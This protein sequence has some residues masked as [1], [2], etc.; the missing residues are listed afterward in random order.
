MIEIFSTL[1]ARLIFLV[2]FAVIPA[3]VLIVYTNFEQRQQRVFELQQNATQVA[4][5]ISQNQNRLFSGAQQ[6]LIALAQLP[7]IRQHDAVACNKLLAAIL[8]QFSDTY[9]QFA[10]FM[11][12]GDLFCS[13]PANNTV[14]NIA[15]RHH[16]K[17]VIATRKVA[18]S[19]YVIS[20]LLGKPS[21]FLSQPALNNDGEVEALINVGMDLGWIA[22]LI[23]DAQLPQ[24]TVLTVFDAN[25]IT[26]ARYP[27]PEKW[28]GK[29]VPEQAIIARLK[30][31]DNEG[32]AT[33]DGPDGISRLYGFVPL[34]TQKTDA[35]VAVGVP[36]SLALASAND[37]LF[38][39][40]LLLG[41]VTFFA[42]IA[43]WLGS[44]YF[45]VRP[46]DALVNTAGRLSNGDLSA[47]VA[48]TEG[49][50]E[51]KKLG[52]A[53]DT[54]AASL[55]HKETERVC[56]GKVLEEKEQY[57]RMF[58]QSTSDCIWNWDMATNTV[59]RSIGF[60]RLFGYDE[61][62]IDPS[63]K[64]WADRLHP[65][66]K[67][68]VLQK[69]EAAIAGGRLTY[70]YEYRFQ[71]KD[72]S[73]AIIDDH[74]CF[75]R[76]DKGKAIRS[77][78]AMR[79]ITEQKQADE[80]MRMAASIYQS[81]TAAIMVTDK[82]NR[83][84]DVNPAF[85]HITGYEFD[86]VVG[87]NPNILQSGKHDESFY[88]E[89]WHEILNE[90]QWQ[91]E[92]WDRRKNGEIYAKWTNISV[93]R[94]PDG[95]VHRHLA[96]FSDITEKKHKD[97]LIWTQA[98]YDI[99]TNLPNRRLLHD[100]LEQE[101]KKA[102]RNKLPLAVLFIDLDR[103][104][105]INDTLGHAKGDLLLIEAAHRISGCVRETDTIGR[106]GGDE[107]TVILPEFG[108]RRHIERIAQDVIDALSKPFYFEND[109]NG[110][111]ISA[112]IGITLYPEDA[113]NI[114]E[115]LKHADQAMYQAK[116]EGRHRFSY[117]IGSM[118]QEAQEKLE[119]TNDL[120]HALERREL[121]VYYQPIID[122]TNGHIV[123]SEALLRWIHPDRGMVSPVIFIPLA[124][125]SGLIHEIGNWVFH[126]A[127][128][129][130]EKWRKETGSVFPVSVNKSPVQ[131]EHT[132][133]E[134]TWSDQL[135]NLDLPGN[136]INVEITEGLLLKES[137][138]IKQRLLEFRNGGIEVSIDDFGT[139][140]SALSYLKKFDIDYLKI[141]R[142]FISKLA[143]NESDRVLTEA[144]IVMA[145]KLGIETIAEGIE[146]EEQRDL[147][148]SFGC[149]Y[150][151]GFLYSPAVP[152][153]EFKK[154]LET[155]SQ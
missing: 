71:C 148:I 98:N 77:L 113:E 111:Y 53:F 73:Y 147:L 105:E 26:L 92:I 36:L 19:G 67:E 63:P 72:G 41:L 9:I 32:T 123:K 54:M 64:W 101:L 95:S 85:T 52:H 39:N 49:T 83:I 120:R 69:F 61:R 99:L 34:S 108:D 104:K 17:Q 62:M 10:A 8:E 13:A 128:N 11:P 84:V 74:I 125:E 117:F 76:D 114:E 143:E 22:K 27:A 130:I 149:D 57:M 42:V 48:L 28:L 66:D 25:G 78:G 18:M 12:N 2:I 56:I 131:F 79:D 136:S 24:G 87:K 109:N 82:D 129:N 65:D 58:M 88:R 33:L 97:K 7:E 110:Y 60:E 93:L 103:F 118:Q 127:I 144:I 55:Q 153:D 68:S 135:A 30:Q 14:I 138:R 122:L 50:G 121:H 86:D 15:D 81:S 90:G 75:I 23:E 116:Q 91:G 44:Q 133:Q 140:F 4:H 40:L 37:A 151:Q 29:P 146:T 106:L 100:R 145:H 150:A 152:A 154:M 119:L 89:M 6:L 142:S 124:E 137:S 139:G 59:E 80:S 46:I 51:L 70:R 47:R 43:A 45:I 3:L 115:L 38:R 16:F 126:E 134:A 141:D 1:R 20:R 35:F 31:V 96:Q 112:S 21:V 132:T 94:H 155:Q 5:Q 102:R 107:F